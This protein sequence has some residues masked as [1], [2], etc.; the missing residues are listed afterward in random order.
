[1][2]TMSQ[3]SLIEAMVL[4]NSCDCSNCSNCRSQS[5]LIEAM[6]LTVRRKERTHNEMFGLN[7][8]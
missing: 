5:S 1:M 6:V 3:S 2:T 4:T 8:L 7:P